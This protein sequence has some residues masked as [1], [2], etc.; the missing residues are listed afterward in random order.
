MREASVG[1]PATSISRQRANGKPSCEMSSLVRPD[2]MSRARGPQRPIVQCRRQV[3]DPGAAVLGQVVGEPLQVGHAVRAAGHD[4]EL[5]VAEPHDREVGAEAAARR[6]HR[7]VDHAPD[8]DVALAHRDALH[9]RERARAGHVEDA[10]RGQVEHRRA[11]AHREVL[12]VD[13]RRPPARVP[14]RVARAHARRRSRRAASRSTRTS[15][16]APRPPPRR[17]PRRGPARA[18]GTGRARRSR[19]L[20][21]CSPGWTIP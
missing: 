9:G 19:E 12:R 18:R 16:G 21:H 14:L 7:R 2:R 13:D 11:V 8:R 20:A 5:L 1:S 6:E 3:R 17:R 15:A 10:E 4:A